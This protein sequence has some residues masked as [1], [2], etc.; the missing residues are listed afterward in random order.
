MLFLLAAAFLALAAHPF[1]TY[2]LS[3]WVWRRLR[4]AAPDGARAA[5]GAPEPSFAILVPA[6]NEEAVILE[7]VENLLAL[8]AGARDCQILIYVDGAADRTAALLEPYR[9]RIDVVVGRTRRGKSHGLNLLVGRAR[10]DIL[11]FTDAN[12]IL[13][14]RALERLGARFADRSVGCVCGHLRYVNAGD[15]PT[16]SSGDLYWRVEETIR[17]LE[18]DTVGVVGADGSLFATR[19][20]L[21]PHVPPDIIDDFYV[22]MRV[23][24]AGHRV[25]R[26]PDAVAY[27]RTGAAAGPEFRR[28]VRIACQAFN[29]HR[30]IWRD[31]RRARPGVVYA[32]VSHRLLKWLIA[33]NLAAAAALALAGL[34]AALPAGTVAAGAG[35][36]LL[37]GAAALALDVPPARKLGAMLV[38]F[39]GAGWGVWRSLRGERFQT[40]QPS[41]DARRPL[42]P[43]R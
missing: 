7:K 33:Y 18:S 8:Q 35:A 32:Y 25:V 15:G 6:Y 10:A 1:T 11:V 2:P 39:A 14:E 5:G 34:L 3:L 27:E 13:D 22:A 24:L 41:A 16:A 42:G 29:V 23:L 9:D 28:K 17:A 38:A 30:L 19:R 20:T 31:V 26:A 12:V 37:A 4:G 40:W 43:H 21:H 36:A